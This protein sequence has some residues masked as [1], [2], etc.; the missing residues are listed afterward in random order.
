MCCVRPK[1]HRPHSRRTHGARR[2]IDRSVCRGMRCGTH[3]RSTHGARRSIG[4]S[5]C[6]GMRC[7]TRARKIRFLHS[8]RAKFKTSN[9]SGQRSLSSAL[10]A[11]RTVSQG[12]VSGQGRWGGTFISNPRSTR[13]LTDVL[14][15]KMTQ[16]TDGV[17]AVRKLHKL[18]SGPK[19]LTGVKAAHAR[20]KSAA[21][22]V[23]DRLSCGTSR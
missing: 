3:S 19:A 5:V 6:R 13:N 12:S 4:R 10:P 18:S 7:G 21:I 22:M 20:S 11:R 15:L 17:Y 14:S 2:S 1:K 8:N 23:R 16:L 9:C